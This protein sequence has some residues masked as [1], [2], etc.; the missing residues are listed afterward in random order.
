MKKCLTGVESEPKLARKRHRSP[1]TQSTGKD[2]LT[3]LPAAHWTV[4]HPSGPERNPHGDGHSTL[5]W[6]GRLA[7]SLSGISQFY[8]KA[9]W[10]VAA[11][12]TRPALHPVGKLYGQWTFNFMIDVAEAIAHDFAERPQYYQNV[13]DELVTILSAFRSSMG[14]HPDWPDARQR[15]SLF[16]VLGAAC[17]AAASL[18]EAALVYVES[19]T[20]LNRDLLIDTFHDAAGTF[21]NQLKSVEGKSLATGCRQISGVF[22]NAARVFQSAELMRVFGL[23]PASTDDG[24]PISGQ[25]DG[26]GT[27]LAT[28]LIRALDADN[29]A[30]TLLS[31]PK[32]DRCGAPERKPIRISMTQ[33][34]FSLLQQAAWYGALTITE[35]MSDTRRQEDPAGIIGNAYKWTKAL[36]RL[37][38]DVVRVWKDPNY[39]VRL[40]DI[41]W[42]MVEPHPSEAISLAAAAS[43]VI[44]DGGYSTATVRGEVCCCT[45]DLPCPASSNCENSPG[46]PSCAGFCVVEL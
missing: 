40:T 34:K 16:R 4:D 33:T 14:A 12:S 22:N 43:G 20:D 11:N 42:G 1:Q 35:T 9:R 41:E 44:K 15:L 19:G 27:A 6:Q 2:R 30:R 26:E 8:S 32:R 31:G 25:F 23:A 24:W 45:G 17:L 38:P 21:R 28:E 18:R 5:P 36:Q 3:G 37:I 46:K 13:P 10:S 39:R 29:V 7:K